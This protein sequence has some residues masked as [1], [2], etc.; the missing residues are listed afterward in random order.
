MK[1]TSVVKL[2][3]PQKY[4]HTGYTIMCITHARPLLWN[5]S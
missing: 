3:D 4:L 2:Q 5:L 1:K